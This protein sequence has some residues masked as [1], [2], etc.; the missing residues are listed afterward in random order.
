MGGGATCA[1]GG[2]RGNLIPPGCKHTF[3]FQISVG[4]KQCVER[5]NED[6]HLLNDNELILLRL[7][8][9][10]QIWSNPDTT[11]Y[12]SSTDNFRSR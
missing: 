12:N 2:K 5:Y 9:S 11:D 10:Y 1:N 6:V 3:R 8:N 4:G 7:N